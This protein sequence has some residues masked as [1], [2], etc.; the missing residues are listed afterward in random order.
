MQL[1]RLTDEAKAILFSGGTARLCALQAAAGV[2]RNFKREREE[3][4][5]GDE[6]DTPDIAEKFDAVH[7]DVEID[8]IHITLYPLGIGLLTIQLNWRPPA[9]PIAET[10]LQIN[11]L[12]TWLFLAKFRHKVENVLQGW[13]FNPNPELELPRRPEQKH[14]DKDKQKTDG[15]QKS[16]TKKQKKKEEK[17]RKK[18][19]KKQ[20]K[21]KKE[22]E[23]KEKET[24]S[25]QASQD[26]KQ[27]NESKEPAHELTPVEQHFK[28]LGRLAGCIYENTPVS[29][30]SIGNWL[31]SLPDDNPISPPQ[32]IN[33]GQRCYHHTTVVIDRQI[34]KAALY[35]YLYHLRRAF[36]QINRPPPFA[37]MQ[38][39]DK[40]LIQRR[41]RYLGVSRE[42]TVCISWSTHEKSK[43]FDLSTWPSLFQ[44]IYFV[45]A[46]QAHA[47]R[48][49]LYELANLSSKQADV[50]TIDSNISMSHMERN[51]LQLRSLATTMVRYTLSMSSDE[52]GGCSEYSQFFS[53]IRK[54]L[55]IPKAKNEIRKQI[56]DMFAIVESGYLE[57]EKKTK[58]KEMI[59][60]REQAEL[61]MRI[62]RMKEHRSK[63]FEVILS[64][65]AAVTLPIIIVAG[66]FG[67]NNDDL[68]KVSF[69]VSLSIGV[70]ISLLLLAIVVILYIVFF[71]RA[72][73]QYDRWWSRAKVGSQKLASNDLRRRFSEDTRRISTDIRR[74]FSSS[75]NANNNSSGTTTSAMRPS[76]QLSRHHQ[77]APTSRIRFSEEQPHHVDDTDSDTEVM[78]DVPR[79]R[80]GPVV[81]FDGGERTSMDGRGSIDFSSFGPP[82]HHHHHHNNKH[83]K[84]TKTTTTTTTTKTKTPKSKSKTKTIVTTTTAPANEHEIDN[85]ENSSSA[86]NSRRESI[87]NDGAYPRPSVDI[88][89]GDEFRQAFLASRAATN[90]NNTKNNK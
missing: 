65:I 19:E 22:N 34:S 38:G 26:A 14:K 81:S 35:K 5:S 53:T 86:N 4:V 21:K 50:L 45:L 82:R 66:I 74:R 8:S 1:L 67:M 61:N 73:R 85:D 60:E 79:R 89:Q 70:G 32:R 3:K 88:S 13:T 31:V 54:V 71:T 83:P 49:V 33:R 42:G 80:T 77:R 25:Q 28:A 39:P 75:A 64:A 63:L 10:I 57:E 48:A 17:K 84:K 58:R 29:L 44:G 20:K 76:F 7:R 46:Q 47:E 24:K 16:K 41:N 72:K 2:T 55:N 9:L 69:W 59:I 12:C 87:S 15:D 40:V 18:Q 52:C 51:R 43:G 90:Q 56:D 62:F 36:G 23:K 27:A 6:T 78:D 37:E 11:E 30:G 68:P